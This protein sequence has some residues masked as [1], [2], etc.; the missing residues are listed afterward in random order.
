MESN[1]QSK[2]PPKL[3]GKIFDNLCKEYYLHG[4]KIKCFPISLFTPK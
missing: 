4:K 2:R 1:I 3:M